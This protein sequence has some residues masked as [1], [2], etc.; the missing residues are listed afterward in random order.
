MSIE[1]QCPGCSRTLRVPDTARG[2]RIRCPKCSQI[3]A[4]DSAAAKETSPAPPPAKPSPRPA[5]DTDP[6]ASGAVVPLGKTQAD[7]PAPAKT[8]PKKP[9]PREEIDVTGDFTPNPAALDRTESM[10]GFGHERNPGSATAFDESRADAPGRATHTGDQ[11]IETS[12]EMPKSLGGYEVLKELGRGGMG[13][14]YLGRQVSLDRLV[15]LKVMNH[16][17]ARN[18]GF[19]ARF[20]RE[21]YA[22]AQLVHHNVVQ[23]YDI[24]A[25]RDTHFFSME[26]VKGESLVDLLRRDGK[27]DAEVA[28]GYVLQ[29]ARGL[30]FG[31]DMGMV[32]RD[33]KPDNLLINDQGIV[34]VADLGLVKIPLTPDSE[35]EALAAEAARDPGSAAGSH[36]ATRVGVAVGTPTYMSPEQ[37]RD[38]AHVDARADVYSLGCT[39]YVLLTGKPPFEGKTVVEVLTKHASAPIVPPDVIVKRVPKTLS[40]ILIKMMAKK[41]EDRYRDMGEVIAALEKYLGI[42]QSGS[43]TPKE[44]HAAILENCVKRF[45]ASPLARLRSTIILGF[46]GGCAAT[47][48]VFLLFRWLTLAGGVLG[49]ALLTPLIYFLIQGFMEKTYLFLKVREWVLGSRWSE[50]LY[51]VIGGILVILLLYLFGLWW[52]WVGAGVMAVA[53][54]ITFHVLVD[55]PLARDRKDVLEKAEKLLRSLRLQGLEER[56]LRQ[57]ICKYSGKDWEE[58]YEA[59]FDYEA[60]RKARDWLRGEAAQRRNKFA[61]WRDPIINRIDAHQRARKEARERN[62]LQAIEAKALEAQGVNAAE[63]RQKAA[64]VA[65]VMV[66]QAA[67]VKKEAA[68]EPSP[69]AEPAPKASMQQ[70]LQAAQQPETVYEMEMPRKASVLS[71]ANLMAILLG[72]RL[73]FLSGAILVLVWLLWMF[74][75]AY[76]EGDR[77]LVEVSAVIEEGNWEKLDRLGQP[78]GFLPGVIGEIFRGFAPAIAGLILIISALLGGWR[79]G[80]IAWPAALVTLLGPTFGVPALGPLPPGLASMSIGVGLAI[81]GAVLRVLVRNKAGAVAA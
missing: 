52:L 62:L 31:H 46:A 16:D 29:A 12:D 48:L 64:Q 20:T 40:A 43:F 70:L 30:K 18:P 69:E 9:P 22:A 37:A 66:N 53:L 28:V 36:M 17:K 6:L 77:L 45:N 72:P 34:K 39:L 8:S 5:K 73:R 51:A 50:L 1:L 38:A 79:A 44:E 68:R 32:H 76:F 26:Y 67:E 25:D 3:V 71:P 54:A 49:L 35:E 14:V 11:A 57:F 10:D 15:A 74:Q 78:I 80:V 75:N 58:L 2:K 59:L 63:A 56:S 4:V 33:V 13:V 24:G 65:D 19:L 27:L 21:A 42:L 55:R 7:S 60:K 61:A 23:I 41:P 81:V 47:L